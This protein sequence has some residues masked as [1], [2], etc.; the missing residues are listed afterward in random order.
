MYTFFFL[1]ITHNAITSTFLQNKQG[2]VHFIVHVLT[3]MP[4]LFFFFL[5]NRV[6]YSRVSSLD[7]KIVSML[8]INVCVIYAICKMTIRYFVKTKMDIKCVTTS[9]SLAETVKRCGP[10]SS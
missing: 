3:K 7:S 8:Y 1:I 2:L 5:Y 4:E 9:L 6:F 10:L